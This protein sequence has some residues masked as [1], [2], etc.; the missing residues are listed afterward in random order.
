MQAMRPRFR[1][2]AAAALAL[3]GLASSAA[4]L[5]DSLRPAPTF[6]AAGGCAEVRAS[7]WAHPL[8]VPTPLL[9]VIFFAFALALDCAPAPRA[10]RALA[11]AGGAGAVALLAIQGLVIGAWCRLCVATDLAA[12]VHAAL[13]LGGRAW[14]PA[15]RARAALTAAAALAAL[16][17]PLS[18]LRQER[19]VEVAS[20]GALP[21]V[22]ARAQV[23]GAAVV[24]DF[25]DFECPFCRALHARLARAVAEAAVPVRVVRVMVPLEQHR[26]A[27]PA[28]IAWCCAENQAKGDQMAERLLAAGDLSAAGIERLAAE[29]GLDLDRFRADAASPATRARL[30]QDAAAA[31][32]AGVRSLPTLYIGAR[33]F[34]GAGAS[35][36]ELVAALRAAAG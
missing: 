7:A 6:C 18:A 3:T 34:V 19:A 32:A 13:L 26:G 2:L 1:P 5:V 22:V 14:P 31:R 33:R 21:D 9:G 16:A 24:V 4:L 20:N 28:A 23:P 36:G 35:V 29:I 15:R 27:L 8:G 30:A 11:L 12:I 10:R 25:V 17:I